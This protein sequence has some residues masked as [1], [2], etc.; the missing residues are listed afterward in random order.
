M[1]VLHV[2]ISTVRCV[3]V[4]DAQGGRHCRVGAKV[5]VHRV[6]RETRLL[7]ERRGLVT[8]GV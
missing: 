7:E 1:F 3:R 2:C 6:K 4:C 5:E 8:A